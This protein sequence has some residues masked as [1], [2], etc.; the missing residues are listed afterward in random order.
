M[1]L[2]ALRKRALKKSGSKG[3]LRPDIQ[4]LRAFAVVVVILDHMLGWPSG[5]FVGVD[6]FFV[7]SGFV[8]TA[9]LLREHGKT[10]HISFAGFY[11][12]R[13]KRI[14]PASTLTLLVTVAAASLFFGQGRFLSTTTDAISALFF[15]ANWNFAA[16]G[17][18]YFQSAGPVS[19]LQH[20]WSLAVEEQ[21]YFVW[22]WVLLGTLMLAVKTGRQGSAR[23]L[24][25]LGIAIICV[26]SF[27]W[28]MHESTSSPTLAYFS[29]VSRAWELGVGA[30]LAFLAPWA[31]RIP[32]AARPFLAWAGTAG[33]IASLFLITSSSVFPAP[34]GLLPVL[35]AALF[36]FA[37]TG[38]SEHPG[39][40]PFTNSVSRYLGDIS[41]SLYLWHFPVIIFAESLALDRGVAFYA[42]VSVVIFTVSAYA[43]HLIEDPVRKSEW[44]TGGGRRMQNRQPINQKY[45]MTALSFLA[46]LTLATTS[47][48][49]VSNPSTS[50][51]TAAPAPLAD[52]SAEDT[53][54]TG[55]L[56]VRIQAALAATDW[57]DFEP[58][59][60]NMADQ[61]VPQWTE[62][63][64]LDVTPGNID[65]CVY[66]VLDSQKTA[67]VLG[68]SIATSWLPAVIG[69]LEPNGYRVQAITKQ[70]CP[71]A[72]TEVFANMSSTT[73]YAACTAHKEWAAERVNELSPDLVIISDS[74]LSIRRLVSKASGPAAQAEWTA[75]YS[76]ALGSLPESSK[77][78][79]LMTPPGAKNLQECFTPLS[80]PSDCSA[81]V[82]AD[83]ETLKAAESAAAADHDAVFIDTKPWFC[84]QDVCPA[85]A[86]NRAIFADAGH[87]T[88][89]FS[90]EL[91]PVLA[92][93]FRQSG[94]SG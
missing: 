29:T 41:Y 71:F 44:L 25:A 63:G 72:R 55:Q 31:S 47:A 59:I 3:S 79:S 66:G 30:L 33:M 53:T 7:I 37:G 9:S 94:I 60:A 82:P 34:T 16:A 58:A 1:V 52:T 56:A 32:F 35:S 43:Y 64:C 78:V 20:F 69:A 39:L 84:F 80:K 91:G 48:A 85:F 17:T 77:V 61:R 36:I 14:L 65:S 13:I 88:G 67:V 90:E 93:A 4:G 51:V 40:Q 28:A 83:W 38:T 23:T 12:R 26:A 19:P 74:A 21:F 76:S 89:A 70:G 49:V 50:A 57:P 11:R 68:D 5:G 27:A 86:G 6:I 24:G 10:G 75:A 8:I 54:P 45:K 2:T 73:P 22:P 42:I 46:V 15:S 62:N 81:P 87:L 92:Q 18:D